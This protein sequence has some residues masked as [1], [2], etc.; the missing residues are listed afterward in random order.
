VKQLFLRAFGAWR[1]KAM[2]LQLGPIRTRR[3]GGKW[4]ANLKPRGLKRFRNSQ[5]KY[6]SSVSQQIDGEQL[7]KYKG[8]LHAQRN[9]FWMY[10]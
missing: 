8:H 3:K 2:S 4:K 9:L 5:S 10:Y 6:Q 7:V 1:D